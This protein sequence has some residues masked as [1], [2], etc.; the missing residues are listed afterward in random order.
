M[1]LHGWHVSKDF[2]KAADTV[3]FLHENDGNIGQ[4]LEY[5]EV[6]CKKVQVNVVCV[7]Y[8]G[9]SH[10]GGT[11]SERGLKADAR[12]IAQWLQRNPQID[13]KRLF[14]VGRSLGGS[15]A[16][17][18]LAEDAFVDLFRGAVIENTWS[19]FKEVAGE[20]FVLF[21]VFPFLKRF[22][23]QI[24]WD[25]TALMH[26]IGCAVFVVGGDKDTFVPVKMTQS[27]YASCQNKRR[28]LMVVKQGNHNNTW[29]KNQPVYVERL[30]SFIAKNRAS[31]QIDTSN[32]IYEID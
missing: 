2:T 31:A 16:L 5:I 23:L 10:S 13:K 1:K 29:S 15:V 18:L 12:A 6:L 17:H 3:L 21:K 20:M 19:S 26:K 4:R 9:F 32:R 7:A 11:P 28:E 22:V 8:R 27:L 25:N 30:R 24:Q 14:L